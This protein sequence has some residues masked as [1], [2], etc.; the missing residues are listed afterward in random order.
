MRGS[1]RPATCHDPARGRQ[2]QFQFRC[3]RRATRALAGAVPCRSGHVPGKTREGWCPWSP[4]GPAAGPGARLRA[5]GATRRGPSPAGTPEARI[6]PSQAGKRSLCAPGSRSAGT[7]AG[8]PP[9]ARVRTATLASHRHQSPAS[10][11]FPGFPGSCPLLRGTGPARARV[12]GLPCPAR[13]AVARMSAPALTPAVPETGPRTDTRKPIASRRGAAAPSPP[14][15]RRGTAGR[16]SGR[17]RAGRASSRR[18]QDRGADDHEPALRDAPAS[19]P[20][21]TKTRREGSSQFRTAYG[22]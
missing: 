9:R 18:P 13:R 22:P 20:S 16:R 15:G 17:L 11:T 4:A 7:T 10:A 5:A 19:G 2:R 12:V 21:Q 8:R 1:R 14:V 3:R 6:R